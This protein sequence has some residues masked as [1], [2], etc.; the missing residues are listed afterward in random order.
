MTPPEPPRVTAY[1]Y[2]LD[3]GLP[4]DLEALRELG[5]RGWRIGRWYSLPP[6]KVPEGPYEV[7][8][9]PEWL[10]SLAAADMA[11]RQDLDVPR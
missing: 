8:A 2:A 7:H 4:C 3:R 11:V 9:W 6:L 10:W 1:R 5:L